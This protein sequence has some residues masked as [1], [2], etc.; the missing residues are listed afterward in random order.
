MQHIFNIAIDMDDEKIIK[1]V[2][3]KA[4]GKIIENL[5]MMLKIRYAVQSLR[6]G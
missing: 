3:E 1:A 4:E 2:C 6:I 5:N